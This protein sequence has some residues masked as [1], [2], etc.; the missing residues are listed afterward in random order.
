MNSKYFSYKYRIVT[1]HILILPLAIILNIGREN[2]PTFPTLS[3]WPAVSAMWWTIH[4]YGLLSVQGYISTISSNPTRTVKYCCD[5]TPQV[6]RW[7][8]APFLPATDCEIHLNKICKKST[9][10][11]PSALGR[12]C[13]A[14]L[15]ESYHFCRYG[16]EH[17][18]TRTILITNSYVYYCWK[19]V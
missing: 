6:L 15:A 12:S 17:C 11:F 19:V 18:F 2:L 10:L 5:A 16:V 1:D 4:V 8:T 9:I 13:A 7:E 14:L 3:S